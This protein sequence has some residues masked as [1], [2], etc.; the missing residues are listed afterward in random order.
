[1]SFSILLMPDIMDQ[2]RLHQKKIGYTDA[3]LVTQL[4]SFATRNWGE[5][6]IASLL[7][8]KMNP[9]N[10]VAEVFEKYLLVKYYGY[11]SST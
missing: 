11:N 5:N 4:N 9:T 10:E 3:Q 1:M 7:A 2:M 8:G 6:F